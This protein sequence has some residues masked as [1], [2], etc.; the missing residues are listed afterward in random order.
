M[1]HKQLIPNEV[2]RKAIENGWALHSV[3]Y[4][5]TKEKRIALAKEQLNVHWDRILFDIAFWESLALSTPV[6]QE[7]FH[8]LLTKKDIVGFWKKH[9][10]EITLT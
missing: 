9:G 10:L 7:F 2:L 8:L 1:K 5:I 3:K 6:A 4:Q